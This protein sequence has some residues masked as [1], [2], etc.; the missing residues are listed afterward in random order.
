[1]VTIGRVLPKFFQ[2]AQL[3]KRPAGGGSSYLSP[4]R[5]TK[6]SL[7]DK[8]VAMSNIDDIYDSVVWT[9][10]PKPQLDSVHLSNC[11]CML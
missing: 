3:S 9:V 1:M 2:G 8:G 11:G 10:A 6:R 5:Q 7:P 4:F